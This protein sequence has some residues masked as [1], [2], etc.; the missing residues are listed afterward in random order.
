MSRSERFALDHRLWPVFG[1]FAKAGTESARQEYGFHRV[2]LPLKQVEVYG[3]R[4][5]PPMTSTVDR[6]RVADR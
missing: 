5:W 6:T 3:C 1:F 4:D 2:L